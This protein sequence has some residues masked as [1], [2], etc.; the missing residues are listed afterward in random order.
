MQPMGCKH[1]LPQT[2]AW[3]VLLC[4]KAGLSAAGLSPPLVL[5]GWAVDPGV[6]C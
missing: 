6:A 1:L 4:R 3:E 2:V 5:R